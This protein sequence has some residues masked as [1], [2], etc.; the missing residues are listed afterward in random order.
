MN[1]EELYRYMLAY[2]NKNFFN[3]EEHSYFIM[4]LENLKSDNYTEEKKSV[5]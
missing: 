3:K 5:K 2:K 1:K 4:L